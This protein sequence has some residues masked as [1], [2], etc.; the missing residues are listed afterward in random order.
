MAGLRPRR[1]WIRCRS[2]AGRL[3]WRRLPTDLPLFEAVPNFSEGRKK[4]VIDAL[5]AATVAG[6]AHLLDSHGDADHNRVVIS[7]ASTSADNLTASLLAAIG[8]AVERIDMRS[9]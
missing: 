1:P 2:V 5:A 3:G 7:A 9:H 8:T 4:T 6:G